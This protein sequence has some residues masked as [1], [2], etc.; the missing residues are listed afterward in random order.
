MKKQNKTSFDGQRK[1]EKVELVFRQHSIT[2]WSGFV[3]LVFL[4]IVGFV[5]I[6]IWPG[7]KWLYWVWLG[8]FILG[9]LGLWRVYMRWYYSYY[10]LTNQRVRQVV[11]QGLFRKA[12]VDLGLDK[13]QSASY[14]VPGIFGGMFGYGTLLIRSQV[15]DMKITMVRKP[16]ETYNV[17]LDLMDNGVV[18]GAFEAEAED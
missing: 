3:F 1:G 5:P 14:E 11:Q 8:C 16:E 2:M 10:L 13:I 7:E 18:D 17:L 9:C 12:V 4:T 6:L 15:G